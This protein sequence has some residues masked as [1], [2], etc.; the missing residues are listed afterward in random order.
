MEW[1][2]HISLGIL[3]GLVAYI[4]L[5]KKFPAE[6]NFLEF[7]IWTIFFSIAPDFDMILNHRSQYTHSLLSSLFGFFIGFV[8]K[9]N[10]LWG[11][12]AAA[13]VLSHVVGDS[14][15]RSGVPLF[16]PLS[17][18]KHVHFPYIGPRLRYDNK[19]ANRGIQ[20]AGAVCI[21]FL[22][23]EQYGPQLGDTVVRKVEEYLGS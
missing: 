7:L 6:V 8:L 1:K 20:I 5:Y 14:L 23:L 22:L 17:Q 12:I 19:Y 2:T 18:R 15:T 9:R 16:Y 21:V 4:A 11:S 3:F 13:A 10:L